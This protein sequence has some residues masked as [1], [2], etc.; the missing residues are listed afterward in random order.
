MQMSRLMVWS[1]GFSDDERS[2]TEY[3]LSADETPLTLSGLPP[4][5]RDNSRDN[6][7]TKHF[8]IAKIHIFTQ[9]SKRNQHRN[10]RRPARRYKEK[11]SRSA[12]PRGIF[13]SINK[14]LWQSINAPANMSM[15]PKR[16]TLRAESL[17][18]LRLRTFRTTGAFRPRSRDVPLIKQSP[19]T[20]SRMTGLLIYQ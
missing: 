5:N 20:P 17:P 9:R 8:I 16:A 7:R 14:N 13:I 18:A 19:D 15:T 12:G 10:R 3:R 2:E 11:R 1:T 6:I 4:K